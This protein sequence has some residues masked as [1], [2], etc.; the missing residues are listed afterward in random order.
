VR[1]RGRDHDGHA[2]GSGRGRRRDRVPASGGD[3]GKYW[4]CKRAAPEVAEALE[5]LGGNGYV[6]EN[7]VA[8]LYR[9]AP[10]N[11]IWEGSRNVNT[12]DVVRVLTRSPHAVDALLEELEMARGADRRLD[13]AIDDVDGAVKGA[14]AGT[15]A[16]PASVAMGARRLVERVAVVLQASLLSQYA[17]AA[18]ADTFLA[19]RVQQCGGMT[20]GTLPVGAAAAREIV[21]RA[22][23]A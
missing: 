1:V 19:A 10:L 18:V 4:V 7:G 13:T 23:P 22:L 20:F 17:P 14:A 12:L 6:E 11:S 15:R 21:Q 8:R 9:E 2:T 5:C 3:L 16:D